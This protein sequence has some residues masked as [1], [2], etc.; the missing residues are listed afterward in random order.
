MKQPLNEQFRRMQKLAGIITESTDKLATLS[1]DEQKVV[2]DIL[3]QLNEEELTE[4]S[5]N[6][7]L[8]KVKDYAKKGAITAGVIAAL[9]ATPNLTTAQQTQIRDAAKIENLSAQSSDYQFGAKL[10][11]TYKANPKASEAWYAQNRNTSIVDLIKRAAKSND[12]NDIE[13]LGKQFKSNPIALKYL[14]AMSKTQPLKE[15]TVGYDGDDWE[16]VSEYPNMV[17]AIKGV[18]EYLQSNPEMFM[19]W[20]TGD[21]LPALKQYGLTTPVIHLAGPGEVP[22]TQPPMVVAMDELD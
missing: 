12:A 15:E 16:V 10:V 2:N 19:N 1:D 20:M 5:F 22:G 17:E 8:Q 11:S 3:G 21:G 7:M 4:G 9:L 6:S 18:M 13:D 14:Q